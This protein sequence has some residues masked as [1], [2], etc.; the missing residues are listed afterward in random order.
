MDI[1]FI[2]SLPGLVVAIIIAGVIQLARAEKSGRRRPGAATFGLDI[3]DTALRPG[4]EHKLIEQE[5]KR[6]QVKKTG[7]EDKLQ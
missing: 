6:I 1:F 7:N 2:L 3:L 4:S 5:K